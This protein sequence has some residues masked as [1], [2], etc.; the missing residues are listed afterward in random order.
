MIRILLAGSLL[1]GAAVIAQEVVPGTS[2]PKRV[3]DI[4]EEHC[5]KCHGKTLGGGQGPSLI[6]NEWIHGSTDKDQY[7]IIASGVP[8]KGM[9]GLGGALSQSEIKGLVAFIHERQQ[10]YTM[11]K[12]PD[13]GALP[14]GAVSTRLA[15]F[16]M[17]LVTDALKTPW[18]ILWL[19][20]TE[21]L[22]TERGGRLR[23]VRSDGHVSEPIRGVPTITDEFMQGGFLGLAKD[24]RDTVHH[25][26]YLAF[27]DEAPDDYGVVKACEGE[28]YCFSRVSQIQVLRG[29]IVDG[30]LVDKSIVWSAPKSTYRATPSFGGRLAFD[31][32]GHLFF[33]VGDRIYTAEEAQDLASPNGKIHRIN[34]DGSIPADNPF[35]SRSG[36]F[37]S[38]WS[39]GHRNPQGLAVE[40]QTGMLWESEHGPRGGDELNVIR[41][42]KDYGWP[43][44]TLGMGYD[45][46]AFDPHYP[47]G[48]DNPNARFKQV[49]LDRVFD[50]R[51]AV[52]PI[53]T[54]TPSIGIS[55]IA[56]YDG[57]AFDQWRGDLLVGSLN[58]QVLYRIRLHA[59]GV[60]DEELILKDFGN[61]RD[62]SPAPDGSIYIAFNAPDRIVKLV[63]P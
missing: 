5:A 32:Q 37:K 2:E 60:K 16:R 42:G 20:P 9:P 43:F 54:W 31:R 22:V 21:M 56:F 6:D 49:T 55:A 50:A 38:I 1:L 12:R 63:P 18:S 33:S 28:V 7:Q 19:S 24:P 45:G 59:S 36:V 30:E 46:R 11:G 48:R 15:R 52:A 61:I 23:I 13:G 3:A 62:I 53:R 14:Q 44:I 41:S 25:W 40:P 4:Y 39:F 17:D 8:A 51:T 47:V 27:T 10:G 34:A 35:V 57:D 58:Q 26:I 29:R